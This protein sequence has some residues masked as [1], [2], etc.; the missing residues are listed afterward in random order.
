MQAGMVIFYLT[1]GFVQDFVNVDCGV[2]K[3]VP[4]IENFIGKLLKH[5]HLSRKIG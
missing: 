2:K 1:E 4:A 3:F 5:K